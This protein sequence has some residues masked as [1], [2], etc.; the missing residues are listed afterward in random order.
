MAERELWEAVVR[1]ARWD[2]R[3]QFLYGED[4][5]LART[6]VADWIET[7]DFDEVCTMAGL[8]P[9]DTRRAMRRELSG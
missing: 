7:Y 5:V 9:D 3:G 6:R 8:N 1:R 2:A 4:P